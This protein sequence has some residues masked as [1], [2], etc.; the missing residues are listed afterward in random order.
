MDKEKFD[1]AVALAGF[2]LLSSP[3]KGKTSGA[4][5]AMAL[6]QDFRDT[7]WLVDYLI[8][9][10]R[11]ER[12]AWDALSAVTQAALQHKNIFDPLWPSLAPWIEGVLAGKEPRPRESGKRLMNRD[13]AIAEAIV[14][15]AEARGLKPTRRSLRGG[16]ECCAEGGSA[17]DAVGVASGMNYKAVEAIWT[18]WGSDASERLRDKRSGQAI[19]D[20]SEIA[21]PYWPDSEIK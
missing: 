13:L 17:C 2:L 8:M 1:Q 4:A 7:E 10:S 9:H 21:R 18:Q 6:D 14:V 3:Y 11:R 20:W 12:W 16:P 5:H 19:C 15:V